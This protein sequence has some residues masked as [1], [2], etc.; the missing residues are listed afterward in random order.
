M[1]TSWII[2]HKIKI[3]NA[4][5]NNKWFIDKIIDI[6][7]NEN[8]ILQI[9]TKILKV[10]RFADKSGKSIEIISKSE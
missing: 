5:R 6:F 1:I 3:I 8:D 10:D 4:I 2:G 7:S 9:K